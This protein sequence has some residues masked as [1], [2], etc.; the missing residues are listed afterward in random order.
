MFQILGG[1][2]FEHRAVIG[3][4]MAISWSL[5]PI[6]ADNDAVSQA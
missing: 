5:L 2:L 3:F 4:A 6:H 1:V